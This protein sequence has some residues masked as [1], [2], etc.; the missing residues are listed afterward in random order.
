MLD[1][2]ISYDMDVSKLVCGMNGAI[3]FAEMEE[4]GG[5]SKENPAGS[6][7]GTGYCEA[8][9]PK[10]AWIDGVVCRSQSSG[11]YLSPLTDKAALGRPERLL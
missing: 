9:C 7:Y 6:A 1:M 3:Y 5:R 10:L 2:E 11:L 4:D 8:Q